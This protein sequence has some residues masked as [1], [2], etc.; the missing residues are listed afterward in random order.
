MNWIKVSDNLPEEGDECI[1][2]ARGRFYEAVYVECQFELISTT[3]A[4]EPKSGDV[5]HWFIPSNP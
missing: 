5:T 4:S 2:W 3:F 1:V